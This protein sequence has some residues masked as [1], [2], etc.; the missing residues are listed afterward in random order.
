MFHLLLLSAL[1]G[2][3]EAASPCTLPSPVFSSTQSGTVTY[4]AKGTFI[5][6]DQMQLIDY[7]FNRKVQRV[8]VEAANKQDVRI[9]YMDF[10]NKMEYTQQGINGTCTGMPK[11][12]T[13][14]PPYVPEDA[15]VG[16][17]MVVGTE[18]KSL[19]IQYYSY[20]LDGLH[21][22]TGLN[23]D[24]IIVTVEIRQILPGGGYANLFDL[25]VSDWKNSLRTPTV[26]DIPAKCKK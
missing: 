3:L 8:Y 24:C 10:A 17:K 15:K 12:G 11:N 5:I 2:G 16:P 21:Y 7:D 19:T 22:S 13:M 9:I 4:M 20:V 1:L 6:L 25:V 14:H 23:D 18:Q 26:L